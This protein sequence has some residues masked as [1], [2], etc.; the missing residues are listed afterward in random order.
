MVIVHIIIMPHVCANDVMFVLGCYTSL[1]LTAAT[2][3][4]RGGSV[5][6]AV[7]KNMF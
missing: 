6:I 3:H 1:S 5:T 2:G 4:S 7:N